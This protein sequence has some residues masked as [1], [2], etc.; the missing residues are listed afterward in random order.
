M[1]NFEKK[2]EQTKEYSIYYDTRIVVVSERRDDFKIEESPLAKKRNKSIKESLDIPKDIPSSLTDQRRIEIIEEIIKDLRQKD[3]PD[4]V[5]RANAI[6][7]QLP[8]YKTK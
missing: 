6:P 8:K 7:F 5:R 4:E 1:L 2:T 3:V